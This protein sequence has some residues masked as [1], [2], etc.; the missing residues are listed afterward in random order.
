MSST[1]MGV[2]IKSLTPNSRKN[3]FDAYCQ[4]I[5]VA[6]AQIVVTITTGIIPITDEE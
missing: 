6:L 4:Y 5:V 2:I 1:L 3:N